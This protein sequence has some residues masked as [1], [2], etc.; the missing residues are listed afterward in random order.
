MREPCRFLAEHLTPAH[1]GFLVFIILMSPSGFTKSPTAG[2]DLSEPPWT[3]HFENAQ[4]GEMTD[5]DRVCLYIQAAGEANGSWRL[6][7]F[8]PPGTY[9]FDARIRTQGVVKL[10]PPSG[11]GAGIRV[12]GGTRL[13]RNAL[14]G[15][16]LWKPLS[17]E[18]TTARGETTLIAEL[19]AQA[20][21]MWVERKTLHLMRVR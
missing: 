18:F 2:V 7:L 9:R 4:G 13:G 8:L 19:R 10:S 3:A 17:Y 14:E 11:G 5:R 16:T 1:S 20:G 21:E 12:S 6:P 15:D